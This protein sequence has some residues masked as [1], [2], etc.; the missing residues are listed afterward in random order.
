MPEDPLIQEKTH[1][2][3][4]LIF[5]NKGIIDQ[6]HPDTDTK[7]IAEDIFNR[8]QDDSPTAGMLTF[9]SPLYQICYHAYQYAIIKTGLLEDI[10][11]EE[12]ALLKRNL[13]M[14]TRQIHKLGKQCGDESLQITAKFIQAIDLITESNKP[15]T[16]AEALKQV[17][18]RGIR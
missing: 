10:A 6:L 11:E 7:S 12:R 17:A 5:D 13:V 16:A 4:S 3:L 18:M 9:K 14:I 15:L 1:A 8:M 2:A